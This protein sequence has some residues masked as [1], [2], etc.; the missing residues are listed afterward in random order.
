MKLRRGE[1]DIDER[2]VRAVNNGETWL[3]CATLGDGENQ[4]QVQNDGDCKKH[5]W[6]GRRGN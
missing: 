1:C 2:P 6:A 3:I 5:D 4:L